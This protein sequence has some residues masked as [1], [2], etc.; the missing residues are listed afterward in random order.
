MC[1]SSSGAK[2]GC[3][4]SS[5]SLVACSPGTPTAW[6][7]S[8]LQTDDTQ[9]MAVLDKEAPQA[10]VPTQLQDEEEPKLGFSVASLRLWMK[11]SLY[12]G[13]GDSW[14]EL[15]ILPTP[16]PLCRGQHPHSQDIYHRLRHSGQCK[17]ERNGFI[18]CLT[19]FFKDS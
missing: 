18:N 10:C 4:G 3:K 9:V 13:L 16:R 12:R 11:T 14:L 8:V 7:L 19:F 15:S 1:L 2:L 5:V 17:L 6:K